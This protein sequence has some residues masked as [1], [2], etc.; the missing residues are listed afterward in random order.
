MLTVKQQRIYF[1]LFQYYLQLL[2]CQGSLVV[3]L[4]G[5]LLVVAAT[6]MLPANYRLSTKW[7]KVNAV[8]SLQFHG[9]LIAIATVPGAY[10]IS[11]P[12]KV[13]ILKLQI[14]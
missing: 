10:S 7:N 12:P 11:L 14:T 13:V 6:W 1:L 5:W 2:F 3:W 8:G 9:S 4:L